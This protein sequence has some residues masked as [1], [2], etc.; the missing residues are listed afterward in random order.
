[1]NAFSLFG[2]LCNLLL[3]QAFNLHNLDPKLPK[4]GFTILKLGRLN[5]KE[6]QRKS[7]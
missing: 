7:D 2:F 6:E 4:I 3:Q 5:T 1:M